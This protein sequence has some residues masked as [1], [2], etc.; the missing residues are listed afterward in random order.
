MYP[1][2]NKHQMNP[3][4]RDKRIWTSLFERPQ[5]RGADVPRHGS[6]RVFARGRAYR[7]QP[8][9][10]PGNL[11][12]SRFQ[13]HSPGGVTWFACGDTARG[14]VRDR[15]KAREDTSPVTGTT[16]IVRM[17]QFDIPARRILCEPAKVPMTREFWVN[18]D[19]TSSSLIYRA[20]ERDTGCR[21]CKLSMIIRM[22]R[23]RS[24]PQHFHRPG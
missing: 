2:S 6:V 4:R 15:R 24:G 3:R 18:V 5:V 21:M 23:N 7:D 11:I 14:P 20:E 10:R 9:S 16:R 12:P 13:S 1:P 19:A 17:L 8:V 22:Q